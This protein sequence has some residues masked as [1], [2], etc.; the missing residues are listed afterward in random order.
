[1]SKVPPPEFSVT[2][3][4]L[5]KPDRNCKAPPPRARI[6]YFDDRCRKASDMVQAERV[7]SKF[8]GL[9][10]AGRP[11]ASQIGE[12][13]L[14]LMAAAAVQ[15]SAKHSDDLDYVLGWKLGGSPLL[16]MTISMS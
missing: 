3:R 2:A 14:G 4:L 9:A 1:V 12:Q 10:V 5:M 15:A 16:M 7:T 6:G 8:Y 13:L 11:D